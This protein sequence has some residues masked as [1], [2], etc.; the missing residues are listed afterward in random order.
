MMTMSDAPPNDDEEGGDV[1][2]LWAH[3]AVFF[4]N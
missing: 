4:S 2:K 3:A 1:G